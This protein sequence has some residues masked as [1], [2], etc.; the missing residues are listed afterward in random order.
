MAK[1]NY[2]SLQGVQWKVEG[3]GLDYCI[4]RH[5]GRDL[6]SVSPELNEAWEQAYDTLSFI[7]EIL[8]E[9][10]DKPKVSDGFESLPPITMD[11][12]DGTM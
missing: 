7:R 2:R 10:K 12:L 6:H 11:K 9:I 5:F 8:E 3:E 4:E 1:K